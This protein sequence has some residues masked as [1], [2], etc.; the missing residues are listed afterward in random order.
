M[1]RS[2]GKETPINLLGFKDGTANPDSEDK[3]LMDEAIWVTADQQ[4]PAWAV[5][6]SYQAMR[7]IP[8]HVEFWDRTPLKEQQTIFGRHKAHWCA[9][10]HGE[11]ARRAGLRSRP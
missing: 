8:F 10:W 3:P 7:I 4:E 11:R 6:G 5:G 1:Q 2:Q 9:A